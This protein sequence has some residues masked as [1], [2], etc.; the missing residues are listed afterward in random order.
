MEIQAVEPFEREKNPIGIPLKGIQKV[1]HMSCK[2]GNLIA[3]DIACMECLKKEGLCETCKQKEPFNQANAEEEEEE[4]PVADHVE[5]N[6]NDDADY[7]DHEENIE[8]DEEDIQD[9]DSTAM[10]PGTIVWARIRSWYPG[11]VCS[12]DQIPKKMKTLL[13]THPADHLFI[14]RFSPFSDVR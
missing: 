13:P 9:E 11:V 14:K 8:E 1:H 7:T 4:Q 5:T 2:D 12:T 6:V 3:R 10:N